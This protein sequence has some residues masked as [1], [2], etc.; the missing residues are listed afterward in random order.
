MINLCIKANFFLHL[1]DGIDIK[2]M[3][4]ALTLS[5]QNGS[6]GN[7]NI[8]NRNPTLRVRKLPLENGRN[9]AEEAPRSLLQNQPVA[10]ENELPP[11]SLNVIVSD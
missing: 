1:T 6:E 9:Q 8:V 10:Q 2:A 4:E 3:V 11:M 5:N 7:V